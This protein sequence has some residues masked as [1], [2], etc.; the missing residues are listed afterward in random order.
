MSA[1]VLDKVTKRF[2][3]RTERPGYGTLKSFLT[4]DLWQRSRRD[5]ANQLV[6]LTDVSATIPSG[7]TFGI[8]GRNGSGKSTLLKLITRILKPD[9]GEIRVKG[10]VAAL[11]ELGAGFH[12]ELTGRE[13]ILING[14]ILGLS[15]AEIKKRTNEII[16]FAELEDF[17]DDPVRTYS[18]GMYMRLGFSVAVNVDPDI[19]LIDEVLSVGDLEFTRKS[20]A[21]MDEFKRAGKTIVLVTHDVTMAG[22]WCD[23]A[24]W[25][26]H[27]G[28]QKIGISAEV[29][30]AYVQ[31]CSGG[32]NDRP[33]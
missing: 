17:I 5:P 12:P 31:A 26:D 24:L 11:I 2:R 16:A 4:R 21:R 7:S 23:Q 22:S 27:G 20:M 1:V 10:R 8:I 25:L 13:N 6:A 32:G 28:V 29:V 14:I 15:R 30:A 9:A 19:L 18:S 3:R 33:S